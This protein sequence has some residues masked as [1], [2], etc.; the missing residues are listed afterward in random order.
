M[1]EKWIAKLLVKIYERRIAMKINPKLG[2]TITISFL[3]V[4]GY[5]YFS[6][7][8]LKGTL[9]TSVA[10][11]EQLKKD[12]DK[13]NLEQKTIIE[14]QLKTIAEKN[15]EIAD[16]SKTI[17]RDNKEIAN[18]DKD[19]K[20]LVSIRPGLKD[21]DEIIANLDSQIRIWSEKFSLAQKTIDELGIPMIDA[22]GKITYPPGT[23]T[24]KLNERYGAQVIISESFKKERDDQIAVT[25]TCDI[26]LKK[27]LNKVR[28]LQFEKKLSY[29][30]TVLTIGTILY[31]VLHK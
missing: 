13:T 7:R 3:V 5:F 14:S 27:A 1:V 24:F 17:E 25:A 8:T 16:K 29:G 31:L 15:K 28:L 20:E 26:A 22:D 30:T 9:A 6:S 19:L 23:I 10:S 11:Y 21:K 18:K 2:I 12:T 4:V